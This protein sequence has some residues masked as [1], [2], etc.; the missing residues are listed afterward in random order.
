MVSGVIAAKNLTNAPCD[1]TGLAL[2]LQRP[3][4]DRGTNAPNVMRT[5][6][7]PEALLNTAVPPTTW[8]ACRVVDTTKQFRGLTRVLCMT[9]LLSVITKIRPANVNTGVVRGVL[10]T[11]QVDGAGCVH[12]PA[13]R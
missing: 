6:P 1:V 12:Q 11:A 7:G 3:L 9:V 13:Q 8:N 10:R 2:T 4:R 5:W